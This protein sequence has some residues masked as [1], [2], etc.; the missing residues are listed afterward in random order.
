[1]SPPSVF[2]GYGFDSKLDSPFLPSFLGFSFVFGRGVSFFVC[3]GSNILLSMVIQQR[4]AIL[5]LLQEKMSTCPS[6]LSSNH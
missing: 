6:T 1:M 3:M 2:D 5:E 4:V